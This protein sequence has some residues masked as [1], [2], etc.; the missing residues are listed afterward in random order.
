[1]EQEFVQLISKEKVSQKKKR[2]IFKEGKSR[3]STTKKFS[4]H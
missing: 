3:K 2:K 1:M 4:L